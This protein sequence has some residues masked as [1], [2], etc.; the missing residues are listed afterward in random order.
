MF[1]AQRTLLTLLSDIDRDVFS[2]M[3]V[4]PYDGPL[5]RAASELGIPVFV[6]RLVHWIPGLNGTSARKRLGHLYR[7]LRT[8][9]SRC[10]ALESLIGEHDVGIVYTNTVTCVEGAIAAQRARKPH[11]WHIHERIRGNSDIIP[12]LPHRL[13]CAAVK[14]LSSTIVFSSKALAGDYPEL[15]EKASVVYNGIPDSS[16]RVKGAARREVIRD[17]GIDD[18]AKLVAVVGALNPGKDHLTFLA[19]AN[20]VVKLVDEAIFLIAGRGSERYTR[21][22]RD[23][24]RDLHLEKRVRLLGWRDDIHDLMSAIDLLVISSEHESFGL[25]AVE[26][27]AAGTPVVSTRCGGPEEIL[28]DGVTGLLVPAKDPEKMADAIGR[29]LRDP[30]RARRY[31]DA[32]RKHVTEHFSAEKYVQGIQQVL[33]DTAASKGK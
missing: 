11:I 7:V 30:E 28:V 5:S 25:T 22:I 2:P 10:R 1:G 18:H 12:L 16:A 33:R 14:S 32:G 27:L 4:V 13:Y 3:L 26:A 24:I 31:G 21:I 23:R 19:A 6:R 15:S 9:S 8:L 17:L 20:Q 29:M